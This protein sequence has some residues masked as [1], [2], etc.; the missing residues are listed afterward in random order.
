MKEASRVEA[1]I[2]TPDRRLRV[3]VSSIVGEHGE[4]AAERRAA[5]R[6]IS[7][8]RLTPVLAKVSPCPVTT[9]PAAVVLTQDGGG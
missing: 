9:S 1:V 7:T 4:L 6:A 8:L 2:R 5:V 3:F